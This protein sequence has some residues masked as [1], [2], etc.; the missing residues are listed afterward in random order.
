[1]ETK[2]NLPLG[3]EFT[4]IQ[5]MFY[6]NIKEECNKRGIN[7]TYAGI[8]MVL[9]RHQEGLTQNKI[10]EYT[11]LK[12]PTVSLTLRNMETIGYITRENDDVDKR[13]T[14]VKLTNLG[15]EV[16]E[17]IKECHFIIEH[18]MIDG[19]NSEEIE[20]LRLVLKKIK[21]NLARKSEK[22]D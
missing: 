19:M 7:S 22:D 3:A 12:A 2:E 11:K 10:V 8:I 20:N 1:M 21:L 4:M 16:D 5:K 15:K 18:K 17:E 14:I 6:Y 9:A 13:N